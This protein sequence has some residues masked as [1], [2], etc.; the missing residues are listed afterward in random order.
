[1]LHRVQKIIASS[2]HCSRRNAEEL[3]ER[4]KVKVNGKTIT[5]GD[6]ATYEDIIMVNNKRVKQQKKHYY[7]LNKPVGCVTTCYDPKMK[8]TIFALPN[9]IELKAEIKTRLY[10]VGRLDKNTS[11]VLILTNDGDFA[12][13]IMHPRYETDKTYMV[14][15]FEPIIKREIQRIRLGVMVDKK[16]TWP[17]KAQRI[18][19]NVLRLTIHEGRNRIVRKMFKAIGHRVVA[20]ERVAIGNVK[21]GDMKDGE[22]REM[23]KAEIESFK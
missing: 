16:K 12:N 15:L 6:K 8:N 11:G 22:V 9:V 19:P 20:L 17:A 14:G 5:I 18:A 1:M 4:G 3:I 2:G 7:V 10:P 13:I 23:T 21:L